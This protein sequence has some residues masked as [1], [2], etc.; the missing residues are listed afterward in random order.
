MPLSR[1]KPAV[2]AVTALMKIWECS[3]LLP[4]TCNIRQTRN[5][6]HFPS[7]TGPGLLRV[8]WTY[9][10]FFSLSGID[11]GS[12]DSPPLLFSISRHRPE[13][14][15]SDHCPLPKGLHSHHQDLG[16]V[17]KGMRRL[18]E[19]S[20]SASQPWETVSSLALF[21]PTERG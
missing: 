18:K 19:L 20:G 12:Q 14:S 16:R 13:S 17:N 3:D 5:F 9:F 2:D 8:P 11:S 7:A 21:C 4:S 6:A 1:R 10:G 15:F